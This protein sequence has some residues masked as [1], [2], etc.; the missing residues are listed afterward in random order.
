M[1]VMNHQIG[2]EAGRANQRWT[3]RLQTCESSVFCSC[4]ATNVDF[5][6]AEGMYTQATIKES[7]SVCLWLGANVMVEYPFEEVRIRYNKILR[8]DC[9]DVCANVC[10]K[11]ICI[12]I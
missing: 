2:F 4:Q 7:K 12:R 9:D 6:I 10:T 3:H 11:M 1:F 5:E 8:L